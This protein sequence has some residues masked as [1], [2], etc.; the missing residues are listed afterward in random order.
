MAAKGNKGRGAKWIILYVFTG[1]V[2]LFQI[3]AT[4]TGVGIFVSEAIE[5]AMPFFLIGTFQFLFK[6]SMITH[7]TRLLSIIGATGL[8]AI[9]GGIAPFWIVDVWYVQST[10]KKEDATANAQQ[11]Q[12]ELLQNNIRRPLYEDGARQPQARPSESTSQAVNID[13]VRPPNGG[14][15]H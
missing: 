1:L 8:D 14:L 6:I 2:D 15:T 9:T 11:E 7:P 13:G 10:V 4:L 12:E 3:I 5:G